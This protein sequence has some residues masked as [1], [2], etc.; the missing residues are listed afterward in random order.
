MAH[1]VF[2]TLYLGIVTGHQ[3]IELQADPA[4]AAIRLEVDGK[5]VSTLSKPPWQTVVDLGQGIVPQ[6][7]VAIGLDA[8]GAEIGRATQAINL[9]R[10]VAEAD[11]ILQQ[12]ANET[13]V[14]AVVQWRHLTGEVP[15]SITLTLDDRRLRLKENRAT[16]PPL[17]MSKP[18]V[19]SANL[20]FSDASA[21]K[22]IVFGGTLADTAETQLTPVDVVET[23]AV[24][25]SLDGC[26]SYN[27]EPIPAQAIEKG[28]AQVILVR[29]PNA[30]DAMRALLPGTVG[31]LGTYGGNYSVSPLWRSDA[32][33]DSDTSLRLLWP[34]SARVAAPDQP[35]SILFTC[36]GDYH[37]QGGLLWF[38]VNEKKVADDTSQRQFADAAAVAG[39]QAM[40]GGHR[41]AVVL[42]LD[43]A[44]DSSH[45]AAQ[46]VRRYLASIGVPLFVWSVTG[47]RPDLADSWGAVVDVSRRTKLEAATDDLRKNLAAQ[48]VV[49]LEGDPIHALRATVKPAC[50]LTM[51][52]GGDPH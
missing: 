36:D 42:V 25:S 37:D 4:V 29:D 47:P 3:P 2:L 20:Q 30:G 35:V 16:L 27:K 10:P 23:G 48:R 41:R 8:N 51:A 1:I 17:D 34:T 12:V 21:R 31:R 39:V 5:V 43:S 46:T 38:L 52:R 6:E 26:F 7:V 45:F 9:P 44:R 28:Q 32:R 50:G 33:L 49:W 19:L 40:S 13:P 18:H 24:P 14:A 22:E 15:K 11:I